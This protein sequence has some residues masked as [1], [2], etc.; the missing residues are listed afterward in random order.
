MA[1]TL[2]WLCPI[3]AK[4]IPLS[5]KA[6]F[7]RGHLRMPSLQRVVADYEDGIM[8]IDVS[9]YTGSVKVN[10]SEP[11]GTIVCQTEEIVSGTGTITNNYI[12]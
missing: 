9:G 5:A 12:C 8:T 11:N 4:R 6:G 1:I 2:I 10:I 3:S 7:H